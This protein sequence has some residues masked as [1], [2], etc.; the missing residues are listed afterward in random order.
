MKSAPLLG[1]D[2]RPACARCTMLFIAAI[3]RAPS[4]PITV[5]MAAGLR[6]RDLDTFEVEV[7]PAV[8]GRFRSMEVCTCGFWSQ[9][10]TLIQMLNLLEGID[11]RALGQNSDRYLHVL[12]EVV[13]LAFADR[14]QYYGDPR[15]IAVP[16]D[17]LLSKAYADLRRGLLHSDHAWPGLPP[18][19]DPWSGAALADGSL[20]PYPR[21][22]SNG[23][24]PLRWT[25]PI[26]VQ[27]IDRAMCSPF[28]R[29]IR[30]P[31]RR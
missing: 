11:L 13:K 17:G 3:L 4:L 1:T 19:G 24:T 29:A 10:P 18:P 9:G 16:A 30:A 2:E 5:T 23:I 8:R 22:H 20:V 7:A 6:P 27:S 28:R 25:R 12:V 26:A 14:H 31:I 21:I 15:A